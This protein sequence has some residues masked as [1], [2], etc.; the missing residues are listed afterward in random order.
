M[1]RASVRE[2]VL[3]HVLPGGQRGQRGHERGADELVAVDPQYPVARALGV[4]PGE[5]FLELRELATQDAIGNGGVLLDRRL[6]H[7]RVGGDHDLV[8]DLAERRHDRAQAWARCVGETADGERGAIPTA[9][10]ARPRT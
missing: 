4:E 8:C 1:G 2:P 3:P 10:N 5:V 9:R 7:P 6:G